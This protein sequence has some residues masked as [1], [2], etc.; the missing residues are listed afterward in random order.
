[1]DWKDRAAVYGK[2]YDEVL[3]ALKHQDDK[4]NRTLTAIA[5]LTAAGVALFAN[6]AIKITPPVTFSESP[7]NVTS[8]FFLTFLG[9]VVGGLIVALAAIGPSDA[10]PV[11]RKKA[12]PAADW[13]SLLFWGRI[14]EDPGWDASV[15]DPRHET[16]WLHECLARNLHSEARTI[17][18]RIAYKVARSHESGAFVQIAILSLSLLGVFSIEQITLTAR[19]WIAAALLTAMLTMPLWDVLHMWRFNFSTAVHERAVSY[20]LVAVS[21]ACGAVLLFGAPSWK[22]HWWAIF[23]ALPAI[24]ASRLAVLDWRFAQVCL[25]AAAAGGIALLLLAW[26]T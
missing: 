5:F 10:L 1:M 23:Y 6:V 21:S 2:S 26:L 16:E 11:L 19:W 25:T 22:L 24:L 17:A 13:P 8:F 12:P 3:A 20:L 14:I 15:E 9:G 7:R 18:N 4:L